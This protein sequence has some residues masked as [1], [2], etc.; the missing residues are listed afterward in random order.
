MEGIEQMTNWV[1]VVGACVA[2]GI[3]RAS[4]YRWSVPK[5]SAKPPAADV[6]PYRALRADER[7]KILDT[8]HSERFVDQAPGQ[9]YATLLDEGIYLCSVRTMYR[10][11]AQAKEVRERRDQLRHPNYKK[12][13]LLATR[14]NQVWSWDITKLLGPAKWT[15]YY[16]YVILDIFSRYVVGW[17]VSNRESAMLAQHLIR[18]TCAKHSIQKGDLSIHSD[19]GPSMTS[20]PV[21]MLLEDLGVVKSLSRPHVSNDNPFS[22]AQF[23]TMKYRPEFPDRFG[24]VED[25]R[26]FCRNF[27][28]WYNDEHYHNAL[29]LVT[30]KSVHYDL[31]EKILENRHD[32]L[33]GFYNSHPERFVKGPPRPGKLPKAVWINPPSEM[34]RQD[35]P[36]LEISCLGGISVGSSAGSQISAGSDMKLEKNSDRLLVGAIQ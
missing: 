23:K 2:L 17:M 24:C 22:E 36:G 5:S 34:T 9:I 8:L 25:A 14:P 18:E 30:P 1:S 20:K 26:I 10:V 6:R 27:F 21:A 13:E 29:G 3:N 7:K 19:R 11:L 15:Y 12:P 31:A 33:Q 4:F 32:V 16:L 35:A 28:P